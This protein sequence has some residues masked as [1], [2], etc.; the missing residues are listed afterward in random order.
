MPARLGRLTIAPR[1]TLGQL[2][3]LIY[4]HFTPGYLDAIAEANPHIPNPNK[5]NVGDVIHF[6]AL[7]AAVHPLPV[8]VWWIQLG[9]YPQLD[10]AVTALKRHQRAGLAARLISYWNHE[11]GLVFAIVLKDCFFDRQVA[12]KALAHSRFPIDRKVAAVRSLWRDDTVFFN[13]PFRAVTDITA[14]HL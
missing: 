7:P 10:Q 2:I 5:L 1:E 9:N 12:E 11:E 8:P 14:A 6:P 4:G 13:N 3:Q